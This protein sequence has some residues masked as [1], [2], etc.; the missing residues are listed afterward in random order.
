MIK[1]ALVVIFAAVCWAV[2]LVVIFAAV[3]WAQTP[4]PCGKFKC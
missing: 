3:C 2:A 1:V 4:T